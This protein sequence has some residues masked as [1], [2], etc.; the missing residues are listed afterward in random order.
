MLGNLLG[1]G[2]FT[3]KFIDKG[4]D[5]IH[6]DMTNRNKLDIQNLIGDQKL[7]QISKIG[8]NN[9]D[10]IG[11]T[12]DWKDKWIN[13]GRQDFDKAGL[14]GFSFWGG[15]GGSNPLSIGSTQDFIGGNTRI[16]SRG[17]NLNLPKSGNSPF[18]D[19]NNLSRPD[20]S[21]LSSFY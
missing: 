21:Q 10:E 3:G 6:D 20:F 15:G 17:Q 1:G 16:T 8:K 19:M 9:L 11:K 4:A 14:P 5:Y 13:Q 7:D 18:A 2:G 12:L